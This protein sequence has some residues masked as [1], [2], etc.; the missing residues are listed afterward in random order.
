[1]VGFTDTDVAK[2][3]AY[4]LL[5]EAYEHVSTVINLCPSIDLSE[6][7]DLAIVGLNR[8]SEELKNEIGLSHKEIM[9]MFEG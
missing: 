1:M 2:M 7:T 9:L 8:M 4:Q 3:R 5:R 6:S